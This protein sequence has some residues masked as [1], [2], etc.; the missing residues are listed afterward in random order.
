LKIITRATHI[1]SVSALFYTYL[2]E[3]RAGYATVRNCQCLQGIF[4]SDTS[5]TTKLLIPVNANNK[6]HWILAFLDFER[7]SYGYYDSLQQV[8]PDISS[9]LRNLLQLGHADQDPDGNFDISTWTDLGSL[10]GP[11]QQNGHDCGVFLSAAAFHLLHNHDLDMA[12]FC[13]SDMPQWRLDIA[14]QLVESSNLFL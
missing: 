4:A 1:K 11:K 8:H 9:T 10:P 3:Y 5:T 6:T 13:Q 12:T 2:T 14:N 7:H